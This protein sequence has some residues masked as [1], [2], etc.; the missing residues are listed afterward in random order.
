MPADRQLVAGLQLCPLRL[1]AVD[2]D[3][4]EA[5]VVEDAGRFAL[6]AGDDRVAAGDAGIVEVDL[7]RLAAADLAPADT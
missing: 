5:A 1:A 6:V 7:R 3:A 2:E 4:V